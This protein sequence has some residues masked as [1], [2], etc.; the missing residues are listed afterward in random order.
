MN[1][2]FGSYRR[3]VSVCVA[4][5]PVPAE[6]L[7]FLPCIWSTARPPFS[8]LPPSLP[9]AERQEEADGQNGNDHKPPL[10]AVFHP[11]SGPQDF[12]VDKSKHNIILGAYTLTKADPC[13]IH[14]FEL[15]SIVIYCPLSLG[16]SFT[17]LHPSLSHDP[18]FLIHTKH[19]HVLLYYIHE[20]LLQSFSRS[21]YLQLQPLHPFINIISVPPFNTQSPLP[22]SPLF[23]LTSL[24]HLS[25]F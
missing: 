9:L 6:T 4:K 18:V 17:H 3:S 10:G 1:K 14:L 24:I 22:S 15:W 5:N 23:L 25:P 11:F 16:N 7:S 19:I 2:S 20:Q 8:L 12:R 21:H 13:A